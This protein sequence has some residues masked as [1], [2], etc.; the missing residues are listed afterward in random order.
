MSIIFVL[1]LTNYHFYIA[2]PVLHQ[3]WR[4]V[5]VAVFLQVPLPSV[6]IPVDIV[7]I[8]KPFIFC[9]LVYPYHDAE[10]G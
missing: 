3:L 7:F 8:T 10:S 5:L 1:I 9:I 6:V 4:L 2:F